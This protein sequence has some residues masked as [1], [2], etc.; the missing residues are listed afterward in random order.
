LCKSAFHKS[1]ISIFP[2]SNVLVTTTFIPAIVA[3][4]GFVRELMKE[5][6]Q[7]FYDDR[8]LNGGKHE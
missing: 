7:R 1:S 3:D 6:T 4:A 8:L 2:F 5:S